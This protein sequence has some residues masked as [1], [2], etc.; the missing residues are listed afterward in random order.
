MVF[1]WES[2]VFRKGRTSL[3]ARLWDNH[4]DLLFGSL[5]NGR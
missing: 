4:V 2:M 5:L 3:L 1:G